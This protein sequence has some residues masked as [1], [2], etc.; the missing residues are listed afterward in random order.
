MNESPPDTARP[1][2]RLSAAARA[3][4][5][6]TRKAHG[7]FNRYVRAL[8][9]VK[10]ERIRGQIA[11]I[12]AM[13]ARGTRLKSAPVWLDGERSGT[14]ER[15]LPLLPSEVALCMARRKR[16]RASLDELAPPELRQAF[17]Q[18]LPDYAQQHDLDRAILLAVG[19]PARDLDAAGITD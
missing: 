7:L 18:M 8:Q 5:T 9:G 11:D 13:L 17:L 12:D 3:K 1:N 19:V 10:A 14:T 4:G 15:E 2:T 16:L 6:R